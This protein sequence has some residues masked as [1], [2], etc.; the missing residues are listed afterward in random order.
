MRRAASLVLL[1][2]VAIAAAGFAVQNPQ[3]VDIRYY[4]GWHWRGPLAWALLATLVLGAVLGLL[5]ALPA[6]L[7]EKARAQRAA[8]TVMRLQQEAVRSRSASG[9]SAPG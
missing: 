3:D 4:F 9:E 8:A 2:L 7:R 5:V 1:L 6:R